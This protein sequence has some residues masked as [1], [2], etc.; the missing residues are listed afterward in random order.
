MLESKIERK[1]TE[2]CEDRG[3]L[4][5]KYTTPGRR[6]APDHI[7]FYEGKVALIEFKQKGKFPEELQLM[8]L[9]EL[10][11]HR[12]PASWFDDVE[13]AKQFLIGVFGL[14]E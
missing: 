4:S 6:G 7:F 14:K 2:W 12:I 11:L 3:I 5:R 9:D 1:L 8:E 10:R 13:T